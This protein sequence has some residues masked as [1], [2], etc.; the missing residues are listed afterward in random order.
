MTVIVTNPKTKVASHDV[1]R[2][3]DANR[4]LYFAMLANA[5]PILE[6]LMGVLR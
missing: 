2:R 4:S 6:F 5:N 3:K 1:R